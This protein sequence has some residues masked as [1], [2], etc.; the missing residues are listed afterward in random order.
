MAAALGAPLAQLLTRDNALIW[1]ALVIPA[2]RGARVL[3]LVEGDDKARAETLEVDTEIVKSE[4]DNPAYD[5][6]IARDQQ[7]LRYLLSCLSPDILSHVL[8]LKTSAEV[9]KT[10]TSLTTSQSKARAQHL[11][12]APQ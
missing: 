3:K 11:R 10:I 12:S 4:V 1:K 7:V 8:G 6:W 5:T 2:L 9:W